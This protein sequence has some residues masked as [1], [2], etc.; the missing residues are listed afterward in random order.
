[1]T[2]KK[3]PAH[4]AILEGIKAAAE[5]I[6]EA[7]EN[8]NPLIDGLNHLREMSVANGNDNAFYFH[9]D[10]KTG[11]DGTTAV[12]I[13]TN[14][15]ND[16][17]GEKESRLTIEVGADGYVEMKQDGKTVQYTPAESVVVDVLQEV[18]RQT[19]VHGKLKLPKP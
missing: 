18:A 8:A 12:V 13:T 11:I 2:K 5:E 4:D 16:N 19:A 10:L 17:F 7:Q 6:T 14:I 3:N 1:M 9:D 15:K